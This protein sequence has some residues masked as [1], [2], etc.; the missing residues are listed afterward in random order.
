VKPKAGDLIRYVGQ[1]RVAEIAI[2]ID[3]QGKETII[4][5]VIIL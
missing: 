1:A 3:A 2:I 4:P 5:K